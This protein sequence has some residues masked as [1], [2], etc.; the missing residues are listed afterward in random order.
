MP[1]IKSKSD[2]AFKENVRTLMGEIGKSPHVKDR[3]QA[4]AIAYA[5]QRRGKRKGGRIHLQVGGFANPNAA[6]VS[7]PPMPGMTAALPPPPAPVSPGPT[8]APA[9]VTPA[10]PSAPAGGFS[11]PNPLTGAFASFANSPAYAAISQ[12][13]PQY[14]GWW[15]QATSR[16]SPQPMGGFGMTGMPGAKQGGGIS[17]YALGGPP[18]MPWFA[19]QEARG[20]A[21]TGPIPSIVPGRVDRHNMKVPSG[22][23]VLPADHVSSLGQ[24]NT[25]AGYAILNHMFHG[26]PYGGPAPKMG[27]GMGLPKP[28]KLQGVMTSSGGGRGH[29]HVGHPVEVVTAGG[30]YVIPPHV[31]A[32]IGG[33]NVDQGHKIL[34]RWVKMNREKH[35]KTLS[36]LPGPAK[37]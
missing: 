10:A 29:D 5:T 7:G 4:L 15:N 18:T 17:G 23:Y 20:L 14:P 26:G 37:S 19:K 31:V 2:A 1:L 16:F 13:L 32:H 21:H 12:A 35:I 22:S 28:P 24:G 8:L 11:A 25:Q 30:E 9:Q 6:P 36:K 34:D 27:R 33:G 3:K